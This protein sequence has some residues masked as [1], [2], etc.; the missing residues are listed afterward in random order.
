M[1]EKRR[2]KRLDIQVSVE[3]EHIDDGNV[4]TVKTAKVDVT[5]ISKTGVG[6]ICDQHLEMNTYFNVSMQIWTGERIDT[7]I[8]IVRHQIIDGVNHY[9]GVF[10]GLTD[11]DQLKIQIYEMVSEQA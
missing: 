9:G 3:L 4:T 1:D 11:V 8:E 2:C 7:V 10:V 5:D 6:F